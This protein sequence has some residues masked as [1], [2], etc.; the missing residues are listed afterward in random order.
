[1]CDKLISIKISLDVEYFLPE[2]LNEMEKLVLNET[3][4]FIFVNG[5]IPKGS[6]KSS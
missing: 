4:N 1:L 5:E 3:L 6:S 2:K